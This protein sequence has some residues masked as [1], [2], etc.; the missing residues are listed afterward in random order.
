VIELLELFD[1]SVPAL[2]AGF[3][4]T[5]AGLGTIV[6]GARRATR[7]LRAEVL[8]APAN[9]RLVDEWRELAVRAENP[10]VTPE[11]HQTWLETHPEQRE[12]VIAV[13]RS[14]G[15]LAA[16]VPLVADG[17]GSGTLSA[18]GGDS[19]DWFSPACR[20]RDEREVAA[21][22]GT[23]FSAIPLRWRWQLSRCVSDGAWTVGL[24]SA[25]PDN[26]WSAVANPIAD[27]MPVA[28]F[29]DGRVENGRNGK[30]VRR[31]RRK[32]ERE[33]D[34][35]FRLSRTP[36]EAQRDLDALFEL[37]AARW[38]EDAFGPAARAFQRRFV[39]RA[40]E[41]GW[42]RL[43]TLEVDGRRAASLYCLRLGGT[44]FGYIHAF[45]RS[46]ARDGVGL[47]LLDH[48][49]KAAV[50]EGC[51]EFN[52]LRGDES[53]KRRFGAQDRTLRSLEVVPR[54]SL[55]AARARA[56]VGARG[57]WRMLPERG[58]VQARR[59]LRRG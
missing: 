59:L 12:F 6:R 56:A 40:A 27:V 49:V 5:L 30:D 57:A 43:W 7:K 55:A 35:V 21:A 39:R 38:G 24:R 28:S 41:Q 23:L 14:D 50:S 33:H 42:L 29:P 3:E 26:G 48:A 32:L 20:P 51:G 34:V 19:A 53:Y 8:D 47:I 1:Q 16:V 15:T 4:G 37:H 18:A 36:G 54:R 11:W 45:D 17:D 31:R 25:L 46:F 44:T 2:D 58:R 9:G 52:F 10:F 22:V 13:R